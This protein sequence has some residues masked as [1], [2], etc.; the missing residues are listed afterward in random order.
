M[1]RRC[2][3]PGQLILLLL[4]AAP[5]QAGDDLE[6]FLNAIPDTTN[7]L[8]PSWDLVPEDHLDDQAVEVEIALRGD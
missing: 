5:V 2:T 4:L 1:T 8:E 3:R 7:T 6:K